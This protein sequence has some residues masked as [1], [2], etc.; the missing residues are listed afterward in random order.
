[1]ELSKITLITCL[2]L[3]VVLIAL[4]L[5]TLIRVCIKTNLRAIQLMCCLFIGD[6]AFLSYLTHNL[7]HDP[8]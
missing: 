1:M 8:P 2:T 6:A 3:S 4:F 7:V 5:A